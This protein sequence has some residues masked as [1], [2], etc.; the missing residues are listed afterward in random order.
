M[1]KVMIFPASYDDVR[2]AVATAFK[3]FPIQVTGKKVLI[4]PNVLRSSEAKEGIVTHPAVLKAVIEK[5]EEMEPASIIVGD[6]PGL[7]NY[8]ANEESFEKTRVVSHD[9]RGRLHFQHFFN[10]SF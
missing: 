8:G 6:N 4:K 7:F 1:S 2:G 5:V 9:K 10:H 3:L